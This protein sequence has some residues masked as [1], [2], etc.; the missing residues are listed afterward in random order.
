MD[1]CVFCGI[2]SG[3]IRT[4]KIYE[5]DNF[6]A[7]L[8]VNPLVEGHTLL[9]SRRHYV[10]QGDMSSDERR[11]FGVVLGAVVDKLTE[12]FS[13]EFTITNSSGEAASQ[14]IP[15]YHV[16][17]IPRRKGDRLWDG[18][19]SRVVLDRSSGFERLDVSKAD[20]EMLAD[21]LLQS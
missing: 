11:E 3:K 21:K 12:E 15:H 16:H 4:A 8:D 2:N 19:T 1:G 7:I 9:V 5:S 20:L 14:S 13:P 18:D 6:Y 17:I 10:G